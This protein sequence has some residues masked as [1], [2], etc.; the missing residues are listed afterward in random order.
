MSHNAVSIYDIFMIGLEVYDALKWKCVVSGQRRTT[1]CQSMAGLFYI[2]RPATF[3]STHPQVASADAISGRSSDVK[4]FIQCSIVVFCYPNNYYQL[5]AQRS[6]SVMCNSNQESKQYLKQLQLTELNY[7]CSLL[8]LVQVC[9]L[10]LLFCSY[11][12]FCC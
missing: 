4:Y 1:Q 10:W 12:W 11:W 2:Y 6:C 5:W 7:Y 9:I 8:L 3:I